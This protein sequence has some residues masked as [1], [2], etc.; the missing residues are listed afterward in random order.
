MGRGR[1]LTLCHGAWGCAHGS[2]THGSEEGSL[3]R[4]LLDVGDQTF[5]GAVHHGDDV[6]DKEVT[7]PEEPD[8]DMA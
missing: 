3:K 1:N 8:A 2:V 4:L 6:L 7:H 5:G